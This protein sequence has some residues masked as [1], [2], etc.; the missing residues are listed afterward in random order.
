MCHPLS[1]TECLLTPDAPVYTLPCFSPHIV[2]SVPLS[3]SACSLSHASLS[4]ALLSNS[5]NRT[6]PR[7]AASP[8]SKDNSFSFRLEGKRAGKGAGC[9]RNPA[10]EI[11]RFYQSVQVLIFVNARERPRHTHS[12]ARWAKFILTGTRAARLTRQTARLSKPEI[13][14]VYW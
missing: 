13:W 9:K 11:L 8:G 1:K 5:T 14:G 10:S 7:P 3:S 12:Y 4:L 6:Q 2:Q